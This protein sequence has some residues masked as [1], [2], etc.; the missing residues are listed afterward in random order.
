[1]SK[2]G[3]VML[4]I[5]II[6]LVVS[7]IV[8]FMFP[9]IAKAYASGNIILKVAAARDIAITIDTIY[10]YPNDLELEY[11]VD[12]SKF[13]VEISDNVVN[14]DGAEYGFVPIGDSPNVILNRP[15][16]IVFQ[17]ENDILT[18]TGIK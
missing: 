9:I 4:F 18:I 13:D 6:G 11:D 8:A 2:R 10:A 7:V 15:K 16:K 14:V 3:A 1:M 12:L 5:M 17:K